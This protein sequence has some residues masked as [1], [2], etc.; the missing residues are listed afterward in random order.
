MYHGS[1]TSN[2]KIY[3]YPHYVSSSQRR[4]KAAVDSNGALYLLDNVYGLC[5][6]WF[7]F[8]KNQYY[9]ALDVS[10]KGEVLIALSTN[11][12]D[13]TTKVHLISPAGDVIW[14][15]FFCVHDDKIFDLCFINNLDKFLTCS[16]KKLYCFK[17]VR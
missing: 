6:C 12:A 8:L 11:P 5:Y 1:L 15:K 3:T 2:K 16:N 17:M 13:T 14:T 4:Y 9:R 7:I 10:D